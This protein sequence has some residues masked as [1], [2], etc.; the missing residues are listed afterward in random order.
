MSLTRKA[1]T[2][3]EKGH[4]RCD[5]SVRR[6]EE[7]V[8]GASPEVRGRPRQH[9]YFDRLDLRSWPC[10]YCSTGHLLLTKG[11]VSNKKGRLILRE[12][13]KYNRSRYAYRR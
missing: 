6:E 12:C 5:A 9:G 3:P 4:K 7:E 1:F 13:K 11:R 2:A 10:W 8:Q